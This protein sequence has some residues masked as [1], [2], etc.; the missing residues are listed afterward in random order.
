MHSQ[1]A[2]AALI[3]AIITLLGCNPQTLPDASALTEQT[4]SLAELDGNRFL[5]RATMSFPDQGRIAGQ[6]P[7]NRYLGQIEISY[8][9]FSISP[10]ITTKMACPDMASEA[11]FLEALQTMTSAQLSETTLTLSNSLGNEMVFK[12]E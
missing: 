10:L 1:F 11:V 5:A 9:S 8:P 7:C 2:R 4:W 3:P 6:A 12:A